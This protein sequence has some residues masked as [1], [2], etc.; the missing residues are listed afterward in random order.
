VAVLQVN[1]NGQY[2]EHYRTD[3]DALFVHEDENPRAATP[4]SAKWKR[5]SQG[6]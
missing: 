2:A 4:R 5:Y 3:H 6:N 1:Q